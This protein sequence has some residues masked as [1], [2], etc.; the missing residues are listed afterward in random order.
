MRL[1][2][3]TASFPWNLPKEQGHARHVCYLNFSTPNPSTHNNH[4][5]PINMSTDTTL[6]TILSALNELKDEVAT[7][8]LG[9]HAA[10]DRIERIERATFTPPRSLSATSL[11]PSP[12]TTEIHELR[13]TSP[14]QAT[15]QAESAQTP[16]GVEPSER[17]SVQIRRELQPVSATLNAVTAQLSRIEHAISLIP[18]RNDPHLT[19]PS[20]NAV[21]GAAN[22]TAAPHNDNSP[23]RPPKEPQGTFSRPSKLRHSILS[24][25]PRIATPPIFGHPSTPSSTRRI[26]SLDVARSP[27]GS[28][29]D[30]ESPFS[31][32]R[33]KDDL[34]APWKASKGLRSNTDAAFGASMPTKK[35]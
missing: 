22:T 27:F 10:E 12:Q 18:P 11:P 33:K 5:Q 35:E 17:N 4:P 1:H 13:S 23:D 30:K 14:L 7:L 20:P 3:A 25:H 19:Y 6:D 32:L 2:N 21:F 28:Y 31:R 16:P 15:E 8:T 9:L 26:A 29:S 34:S 24:S